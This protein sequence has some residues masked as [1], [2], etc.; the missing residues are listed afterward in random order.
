MYSKLG[1][2]HRWRHCPVRRRRKAVPDSHTGRRQDERPARRRMRRCGGW[3]FLLRPSG[4]DHRAYASSRLSRG[5]VVLFC[6][7][8]NHADLRGLL[9][10]AEGIQTAMRS[11]LPQQPKSPSL[12]RQI[13]ASLR[14][15]LDHDSSS[16]STSYGIAG[17]A[18]SIQII[19][20]PVSP[21]LIACARILSSIAALPTSPFIANRPRRPP[22]LGGFSGPVSTLWTCFHVSQIMIA[23]NVCEDI[24]SGLAF[25]GPGLVAPAMN[26]TPSR[27]SCT[28]TASLSSPPL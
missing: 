13:Q 17:S 26:S 6:E 28:V 24:P 8:G 2:T 11:R 22:P 14:L 27:A 20:G 21:S 16:V 7:P 12:Q 19:S 1:G 5:N 25:P 9:G 3:S 18:F 10:G 23:H 15:E 4:A